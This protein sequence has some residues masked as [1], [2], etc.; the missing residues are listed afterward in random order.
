MTLSAIALSTDALSLGLQLSAS[1]MQ[2]L[3]RQMV[4]FKETEF[5]F[6]GYFSFFQ[7]QSAQNGIAFLGCGG[8]AFAR[9]CGT[10]DASYI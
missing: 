2:I 10:W 9:V 4:S 3:R 5:P 1:L 7:T 8:G 6:A